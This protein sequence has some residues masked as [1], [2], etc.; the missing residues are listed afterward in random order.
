LDT[1][2]TC[3][4]D[5]RIVDSEKNLKK[6]KR[7]KQKKEKKR[8]KDKK[9]KKDKREKQTKMNP[10]NSEDFLSNSCFDDGYTSESNAIDDIFG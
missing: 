10:R 7:K 6:R 9:L 2:T 4:S 1:S 8:N 5:S 3:S